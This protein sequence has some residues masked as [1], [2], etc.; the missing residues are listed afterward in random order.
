MP[1]TGGA[2][3]SRSL[4]RQRPK[5]AL[6]FPCCFPGF[7]TAVVVRLLAQRFPPDWLPYLRHNVAHYA[8]LT[9]AE[10]AKLRDDLRVFLAEKDWEGCGG[11]QITDEI[12]VTIA[13]QAMLLVLA[14]PHDYY[15]GVPS[16]LVYPGGC[17][18][19]GA[20]KS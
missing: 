8:Y 14:M 2:R 20:G 13:A 11:L 9:E 4:R 19:L 7:A 5:K 16:I 15:R 18:A 12:K 1:A 10:Q 6:K 3:I 17:K